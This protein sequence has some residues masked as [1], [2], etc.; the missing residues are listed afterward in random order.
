MSTTRNY[1]VEEIK[2]D[3]P[4][5]WDRL[6]QR[7]RQYAPTALRVSIGLVFVWFGLLKAIGESPVADLVHATV[8]FVSE[9][10]LMP[11][12]GVVE[13]VLGVALM[14]G[15]PRRLALI[16]VAGHLAGTFLVFVNA[17]TLSWSDGNPL[18]LTANGEFVL[19]NV[20][21]ICAVL[22]LLGHRRTVRR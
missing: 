22:M 11:V 20:V 10:L 19:K 13:I 5:W 18:L 3:P 2:P 14:I 21:L 16:A 4:P 6:E 15:H 1:G 17:P 8:P 12:L 9:G 7:L